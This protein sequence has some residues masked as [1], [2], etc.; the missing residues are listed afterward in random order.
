MLTIL[1]TLPV[2]SC[3]CK[4]SISLLRHM[5]LHFAVPCLRLDWM[6]S[7]CCNIIEIYHTQQQK[8]SRSL[9]IVIQAHTLWQIYS[10]ANC[11]LEAK[12]MFN[13]A[14]LYFC[15]TFLLIVSLNLFPLT[16]FIVEHDIYMIQSLSMIIIQWPARVL[17]MSEADYPLQNLRN[18]M[19]CTW[20]NGIAECHCA[21]T[22]H[23]ERVVEHVPCVRQWWLIFI[24]KQMISNFFQS[25]TLQAA[26]SPLFLLIACAP[27]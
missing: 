5:K 23:G 12:T 25:H 21:C 20:H 16:Y 10:L 22:C 13:L 27:H 11:I 7:Q 15:C 14:F 6:D 19:Q 18:T 17:S 3:E 2:T 8:L 1:F 26:L 9:Y 24:N 4:Q